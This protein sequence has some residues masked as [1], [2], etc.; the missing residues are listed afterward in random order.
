M[1]APTRVSIKA[2]SPNSGTL[3]Q[4]SL[5]ATYVAQ[6]PEGLVIGLVLPAEARGRILCTRRDA[7]GWIVAEVGKPGLVCH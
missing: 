7:T 4:V 5:E 2:R 3:H 1:A 6:L